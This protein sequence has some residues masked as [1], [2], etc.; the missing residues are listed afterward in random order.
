MSG[1]VHM[2]ITSAPPTEPSMGRRACR[3]GLVPLEDEETQITY[4]AFSCPAL[5]AYLSVF[6]KLCG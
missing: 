2:T 4:H 1:F 3:E 6:L 5:S